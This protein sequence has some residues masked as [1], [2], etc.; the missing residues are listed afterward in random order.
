MRHQVAV[1][2]YSAYKSGLK[3]QPGKD[4]KMSRSRWIRLK[5]M[6]R[7]NRRGKKG[8]QD[9]GRGGNSFVRT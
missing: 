7:K 2:V 9:E 5:E 8:L 4:S 3:Q 1:T 6:R